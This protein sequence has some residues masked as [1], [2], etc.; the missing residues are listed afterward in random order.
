VTTYCFPN[1]DEPTIAL[2]SAIDRHVT[3]LFDPSTDFGACLL[4]G[5][6][7]E[8]VESCVEGDNIV[9]KYQTKD[10]VCVRRDRFGVVVEIVVNRV[11]RPYA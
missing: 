7:I 6:D 11:A 9:A 4:A 8:F 1:L 2:R 5:C 10:P 3:P